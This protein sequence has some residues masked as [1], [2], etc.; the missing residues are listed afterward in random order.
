MNME[1]LAPRLNKNG[2]SKVRQ[3]QTLRDEATSP[4]EALVKC[5]L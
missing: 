4:Q 1:E 3:F 5:K 2:L